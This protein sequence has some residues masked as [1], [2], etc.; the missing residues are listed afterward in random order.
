[1]AMATVSYPIIGAPFNS[2]VGSSS[3][4]AYLYISS[5]PPIVPRIASV[6][7]VPFD[8]GGDVGVNWIRSG[9]DARGISRVTSYLVERSVPPGT[10]GFAWEALATIG[11]AQNPQY[12]LTA[13]TRYDSSANT[14]G[15]M[16]FRV[17]SPH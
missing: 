8:Q 1:M 12:S 17:D 7:D 6:K 14:S 2:F 10:Q 5:S 3:G 11:A 13:S 4:R 9:Y 15:T 16:Y